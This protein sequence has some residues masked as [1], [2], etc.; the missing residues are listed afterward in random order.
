M[1]CSTSPRPPR[2]TPWWHPAALALGLVALFGAQKAHGTTCAGATVLAYQNY[3]AFAIT[4]GGTN[5]INSGNA[6]PCGSTSYLGGQEALYTFTSQ[7]TGAASFAYVG[8]SWTGI[9]L[10]AG[11]P[12]SG[13]VCV[14][15]ITS[16]ATSKTLN[17][18]VTNGV[19]YYLM[20]DTWPTPNSPCPGT[21]AITLPPVAAPCAGIPIP[22]ATT[23]PSASCSGANFNLGITNN[24]TGSGVS[25]QWYA[26]I[27]GGVNYSP[28]GPNAATYT[29]SLTQ[30]TMYYCDVT[31][32]GNG[33][34][35]SAPITV[36]LNTSACACG[37]YSIT[38]I[39]GNAA[40]TE[41]ASVTVG[42]MTNNLNTCAA[43]APGPGSIAGRYSNFTTTVAGHTADQ[44]ASVP[45]TLVQ[46]ACGVSNYANIFQIYV[47][48]NQNNTFE[49]SERMFEGG[50]GTNQAPGISGSF[51]VPLTASAGSTRM[52]VICI[53]GG[54]LGTDYANIGYTWGETEDYCF[55]VNV[56]PPCVGIPTPGNTQ[57]TLSSVCPSQSFT[58][59]LQNATPGAG[60]D[61][62]WESSPD[63]INWGPAPGSPNA[64]TWVTTQ[65]ADTYY[66]CVVTCTG[67]GS[68]TS[69]EVLVTM[70]SACQCGAYCAT[71]NFGDGACITSV[72]LNTLASTTALCVPSPGYT[73]K[74]ETTTLQKGLTYPLTV[75]ANADVYGGAI[76]SVWFDWNNDATF[77]TDEWAQV[78][79][80]GTTGTVNIAVPLTAFEGT[81]RMRVRSR[82]TGNPNGAGDGC[83]SMGSGTT[84]DFCIT[85]APLTACSGTPAPG[86]TTGPA[87]VCSGVNL[88]LGMQ[89]PPAFGGITYQWY[90]SSDGVNYSPVGGNTP[91]YSTTQSVGTWYYCDVTC[92][93]PGGGTAS[94]TP[95]EVPMSP[96]TSCYC[97]AGVGP[98]STTD[99]QVLSVTL[100]GAPS[101]INYTYTNCPTGGLGVQ[102][103]TGLTADLM[104]SDSYTITVDFSTCGGS[105]FGAGEVWIDYDHSG[106]FDPTE[107]IGALSGQPPFV[108]NFNFTVPGTALLGVTR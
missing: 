46:N 33:T 40:D 5:D 95:L 69:T 60:V 81:I 74:T 106:T 31:C 77:A 56:P 85:L 37:A 51:I 12:T 15:S 9:Q 72:S 2:R 97:T 18:T 102:D 75:T 32:A 28:V 89:N 48:W 44:G 45:F 8:V 6:V 79:T 58:L 49:V 13:G 1:N 87:S 30:T 65:A 76:M 42:S 54:T 105:Y 43:A 91:T 55:T 101:S 63:N 19:T 61:Y 93:E 108:G 34:G 68:G 90:A 52:R 104:L 96:F 10:W 41:L 36:N 26:S 3:P 92:T 38:G 50:S 98:T 88:T 78:F 86:N 73:F 14:A 47:D 59:S 57:T 27:D 21:L 103:L 22:G 7:G 66:R 82:G 17:T 25:Y 70:G 80:T 84:E 53:E 16:S 64:P 99:S 100:T 39:A 67:N 107:S 62:A 94:T 71:S 4:C 35:S 24:P 29:T 23:G 83:T 20:V 11:C